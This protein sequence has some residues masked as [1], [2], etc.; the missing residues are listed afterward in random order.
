[1]TLG[2]WHSRGQYNMTQLGTSRVP[3]SD[4]NTHRHNPLHGLQLERILVAVEHLLEVIMPKPHQ[5][6]KNSHFHFFNLFLVF[7]FCSQPAI[8]L[9]IQPFIMKYLWGQEL[10][11]SQVKEEPEGLAWC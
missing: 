5:G 6:E 8:R 11:Y 3:T 1:M 2:S 4:N 9:A 10:G 7:F